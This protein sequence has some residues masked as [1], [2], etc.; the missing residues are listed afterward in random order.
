MSPARKLQP[1]MGIKRRARITLKFR[2]WLLQT[3]PSQLWVR[4]EVLFPSMQKVDMQG[5][6]SQ[7]KNYWKNYSKCYWN[8]NLILR[9]V[10]TTL[11]SSFSQ[12]NKSQEVFQN[13]LSASYAVAD[14][15][16]TE[17]PVCRLHHRSIK[18]RNKLKLLNFQYFSS[19]YV[20]IVANSDNCD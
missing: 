12:Y 15:G 11:I 10:S 20:T 16:L 19:N 8:E 2:G 4:R 3:D 6:D 7:E 5:R 9:R 13:F 17:I 1:A 18:N 14:L